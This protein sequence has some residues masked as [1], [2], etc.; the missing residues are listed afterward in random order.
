MKNKFFL[1]IF[2]I[3]LISI[4][5]QNVKAEESLSIYNISIFD[6][7][8]I[9]V[10]GK[11]DLKREVTVRKDGFIT[12]PP[13]G[14][15]QASGKTTQILSNE[16]SQLLKE[17]MDKPLVIVSI[18]KTKGNKITIIGGINNPGE[19]YIINDISL[20]EAIGMSGGFSLLAEENKNIKIIRKDS[21][22]KIPISSLKDIE[23]LKDNILLKN[24]DIIIVPES[25]ENFLEKVKN[26]PNIN[27][28]LDFNKKTN[29]FMIDNSNSNNNNNNNSDKQ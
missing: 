27:I 3:I 2:F 16:I 18:I 14:D 19:Y 5:N 13:I 9:E 23:N 7:L 25:I 24:N 29:N 26:R 11:D 1:L 17:F 12:Y 20:L 6:I 28:F 10:W 21:L 8:N 15:I 22:I 4:I